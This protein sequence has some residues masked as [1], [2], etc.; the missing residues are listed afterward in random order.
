M[1]SAVPEALRKAKAPHMAG[2]R[3]PIASFFH[4]G[5]T[6]PCREIARPLIS[7]PFGYRT[8]LQLAP[9]F[10]V[11]SLFAALGRVGASPCR[12]GHSRRVQSCHALR[13][14]TVLVLG[15][16]AVALPPLHINDSCP[17]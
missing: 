8:V 13:R 3:S 6:Q 9:S 11:P 15:F 1:Y 17:T 2:L 16:S 14:T 7:E 5:W 12:Y 10:A 4:F